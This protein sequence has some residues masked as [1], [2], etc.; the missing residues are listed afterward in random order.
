MNCLKGCGDVD[1]EAGMW[2]E[3][4]QADVDFAAEGLDEDD[5]KVS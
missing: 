2:R 3:N 4:L 1:F 5:A